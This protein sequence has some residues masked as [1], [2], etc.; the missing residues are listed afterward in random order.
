MGSDSTQTLPPLASTNPRTIARPRPEPRWPAGRGRARS[1]RRA[2]RCARAGPAGRRGRGR[3]S[4]AGCGRR[5]RGR[6]RRRG[7]RP[8]GG[9]CAK[10]QSEENGQPD[11]A[12]LGQGFEIDAVRAAI[13]RSGR[14]LVASEDFEA[15]TDDRAVADHCQR[16]APALE[17][18]L[19]RGVVV[20]GGNRSD[21]RVP[22]LRHELHGAGKRDAGDQSQRIRWRDFRA[23]A[24]SVTPSPTTAPRE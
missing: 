9:V 1:G 10:T 11:V 4:A 2:R 5:R 12:V 20:V 7:G 13:A 24:T 17:A 3:R 18:S 21:P 22:V 23:R 16:I 8:S 6:G 19:G 15:A 14:N